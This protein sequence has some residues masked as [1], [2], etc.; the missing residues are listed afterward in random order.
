[1]LSSSSEYLQALR[2]RNYLLFLEW[3]CFLISHYGAD[4]AELS[5]DE[6]TDLLI[7]EWLNS[8]YCTDDLQFL[9]VV[10][11][12][13]ETDSHGL[14]SNL[15]YA[16]TVIS[17]AALLCATY[18]HCGVQDQYRVS[19]PMSGQDIAAFMAL[20]G[21]VVDKRFFDE[22]LAEQQREFSEK[23]K[24]ISEAELKSLNERINPLLVLRRTVNGYLS[25]LEPVVLSGD[26]LLVSRHSVLK[27]LAQYLSEHVELNTVVHAEFAIYIN[28]IRELRPEPFEE[29][30]LQTLAPLTV[31]ENPW[32]FA[33][34][35]GISFFNLLA[36]SQPAADAKIPTFGANPAA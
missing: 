32:R 10:H 4:L 6:L 8:G 3:P 2:Q 19:L 14:G 13:S 25:A 23:I 5:A 28:K 36:V 9:A 31:T 27:R 16:L 15:D 11:R 22:V 12:F 1:M 30:Y 26:E 17:S 20:K 24:A 18:H 21:S 29:E 34:N 33:A 35:L 7:F